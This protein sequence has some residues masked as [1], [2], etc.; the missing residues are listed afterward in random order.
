MLG[1][2]TFAAALTVAVV[3]GAASLSNTSASARG[4]IGSAISTDGATTTIF[5]E[6]KFDR[7]FH[8][9]GFRDREFGEREFR[10]REFG[11]REFGRR[12]FG[13]REVSRHRFHDRER[14]ER[15]VTRALIRAFFDHRP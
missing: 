12:E 8:R 15:F 2:K 13:R 1:N 10:H 4:R 9:H 14:A 3:V 5:V 11:D 6:K 7:G